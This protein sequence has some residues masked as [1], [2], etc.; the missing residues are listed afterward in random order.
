VLCALLL[1]VLWAARGLLRTPWENLVRWE[2]L[3]D[4]DAI[5]GAVDAHAKLRL[6]GPLGLTLDSYA[7]TLRLLTTHVLAR[8]N[9][10]EAIL[11]ALRAARSYIAYE[12]LGRVD[13]FRFERF[14][15]A[16]VLE[17]PRRARLALVCDG[18]RHEQDGVISTVFPIPEGSRRCRGEAWLGRR[19]WIATSYQRIA[20]EARPPRP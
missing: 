8:E 18:G 4:T 7:R 3:P 14:G 19:L 15:S 5:V 6:L 9:T 20:P 17:A 11:E 2:Q 16:Y 10:R 12:G 13:R 1:P